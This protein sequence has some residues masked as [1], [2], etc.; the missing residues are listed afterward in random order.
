MDEEVRLISKPDAVVMD[1]IAFQPDLERLQKKLHVKK[2]SAHAEGLKRLVLEAQTIARP[3]AVYRVAYID[4]RS[5]GSVVIDGITLTSRVLRV[6]LE[7][8]PRRLLFGLAF[9]ARE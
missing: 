2:G 7:N 9:C 4:S 3:R 6:N 1:G 5:E 8:A